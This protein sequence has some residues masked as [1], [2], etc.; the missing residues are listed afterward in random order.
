LASRYVPRTEL[1]IPDGF[2]GNSPLGTSDVHDLVA[3][4]LRNF[5]V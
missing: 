1:A 2:L 3:H 4:A 5:G